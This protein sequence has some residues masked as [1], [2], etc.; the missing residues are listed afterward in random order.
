MCACAFARSPCSNFIH[1]DCQDLRFP[2]HKHLPVQ[3]QAQLQALQVRKVLAP[4]GCAI[5][6]RLQRTT[7]HLQKQLLLQSLLLLLKLARLKAFS[8]HLSLHLSYPWET[9][10]MT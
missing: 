4:E 2:Y 8:P 7:T 6:I 10:Q 9:Q 1:N 5:V 3:H